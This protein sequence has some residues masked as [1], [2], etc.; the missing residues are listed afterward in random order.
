MLFFTLSL[1][2]LLSETPACKNYCFGHT[3]YHLHKH[4]YLGQVGR[5]LLTSSSL[6]PLLNQGQSE[7]P[8]AVPCQILS[9]SNNGDSTTSL[10]DLHQS[11]T[12]PT[13]K[14][15]FLMFWWSF[16]H[17]NLTPLPSVLSLATNE[18]SL[19]PTTSFPLIRY[20]CTW[21]RFS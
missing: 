15:H 8:R 5:D 6:V 1:K 16:V 4:N 21:I 20:L 13:V 9:I 10:E 12:I 11:L 18:K 2:A 3:C 19:A 7:L 17:F 14:E